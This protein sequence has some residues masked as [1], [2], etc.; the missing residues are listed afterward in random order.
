MILGWSGQKC[1]AKIARPGS[2]M[3]QGPGVQ[4]WVGREGER[5]RGGTVCAYELTPS[6]GK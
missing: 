6:K 5:E 4:M 1:D 3:L 2:P